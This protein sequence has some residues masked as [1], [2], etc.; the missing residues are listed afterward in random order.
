MAAQAP[1]PGLRERKKQRTRQLIADT[2]WRLF[3]DRGFDHVPV[4]E[5]A[6]EAEV[7]EAT[8]F[9]YFPTKEDLVF[10][11]MQAFEQELLEAVQERGEQESLVQ[12]FGRFVLQAR[13]A[14]ASDDPQA[15]E[16]MRTAARVITHSRSLL[17]RER[18]I[19][20]SYTTT[21]AASIAR[22]RG[23][24]ADDVEAWVVANALIGVHRALIAQVHRQALAGFPNRRIVAAL[25]SNGR[26]AL[27][28]LEH[29]V[30]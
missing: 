24:A 27:D 20:D 11:R 16:A 21:L 19:L 1:Q 6:N 25:R 7:S 28:R 26:R 22:E 23:L 12:A 29:G 10:H 18:D 9:N 8:V 14:L 3:A 4:A 30:G 5:I 2:A 15:T 17:A 13:G